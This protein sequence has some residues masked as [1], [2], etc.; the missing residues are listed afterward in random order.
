MIESYINYNKWKKRPEAA[1]LALEFY[2]ALLP[3]AED[4]VENSHG[5][6]KETSQKNLQKFADFV[7]S[8][9]IKPKT[10]IALF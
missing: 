10:S 3:L 5:A 8:K 9:G 6:G 7:S 2:Q 4:L 1:A